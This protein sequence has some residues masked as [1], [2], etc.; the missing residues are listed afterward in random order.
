MHGPGEV[1]LF[2]SD[3]AGKEKYHLCISLNGRYLYLNS[4]KVRTY[5]GDLE[6]PC[7][8]FPFL[9]AT[10]SGK[11]VV[12]CAL[13]LAPTAKDLAMKRVVVKGTVARDVLLKIVEFVEESEVIADDERDA[14]LDGLGD[15]L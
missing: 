8:D 5:A 4:P 1:L 2:W 9:P 14:I 10:P 13:V 15:W 12:S 6:L 7:T 11:S 3:A